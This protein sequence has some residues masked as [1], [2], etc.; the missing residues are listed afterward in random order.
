MGIG[1][2]AG[3]VAAIVFAVLAGFMIYPLIKLGKLFE[4]IGDTVQN[5]ANHAI[6]ALDEGVNTVKEVNKTLTDVNSI[7]ESA[8]YTARNV[9]ALT[10][11]YGSI[12]AKPVIKLASIFWALKQTAS[13]FIGKSKD[14]KKDTESVPDHVAK[15]STR[16]SP[17]TSFT[18]PASKE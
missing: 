18:T 7:S 11:L 15:D 2:I 6:P 9:G 3:L 16:P 17:S 8:S 1:E 13:S 14:V 12:L 4:K 5:T 10:D